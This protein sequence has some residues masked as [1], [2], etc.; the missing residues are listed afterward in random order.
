MP[1]AHPTPDH[2]TPLFIALGAATDP[3][4][5]VRTA[6]EGYILGLS[7]RSFATVD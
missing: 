6:I 2:Y 4:R 5:P 7:K 3:G 1:F